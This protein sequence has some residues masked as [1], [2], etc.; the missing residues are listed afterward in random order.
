MSVD[1]NFKICFVSQRYNY[2]VGDEPI[3]DAAK[4]YYHFQQ[5]HGTGLMGILLTVPIYVFLMFFA[6]VVFYMYFLR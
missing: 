5:T 1:C 6:A 4:L 3:A 2:E